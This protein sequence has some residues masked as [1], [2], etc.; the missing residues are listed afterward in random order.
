[1]SPRAIANPDDL[2][3]FARVLKQFNG[4]LGDSLAR[5][6]GQFASLG[7]TWRDQEHR[8]FAREFE[9]TVRVLRHFMRSADEQIPFLL[10][11]ARRLREYLNQR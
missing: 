6:N 3:H 7:E 9:Q 5:L 8:K 4:Q 10:R 2:E 11:K 1:M